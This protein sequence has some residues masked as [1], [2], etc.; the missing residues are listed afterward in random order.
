M[1]NLTHFFWNRDYPARSFMR[2]FVVLSLA[3]YLYGRLIDPGPAWAQAVIAY[4]IKT[5]NL[6]F[7]QSIGLLGLDKPSLWRGSGFAL[8]LQ[9]LITWPVMWVFALTAGWMCRNG[10]RDMNWLRPIIKNPPSIKT[11]LSNLGMPLLILGL[12]YFPFLGSDGTR[13]YV[14]SGLSRSI[15][16]YFDSPTTC[17]FFIVQGSVIV[18]LAVIMFY[19]I[20]TEYHLTFNKGN[21]HD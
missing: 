18:Y 16:L 21:R 8:Q 19:I 2:I 7:I 12:S 14:P 3:V 6:E 10:S 11:W 20:K 5:W 1:K 15:G 4:L 17:T 13:N 9:L